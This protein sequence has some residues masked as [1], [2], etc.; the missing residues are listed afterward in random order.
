MASIKDV[1]EAAGVSTATVSR[2]LAN[3]PH[4]R[5]AVRERVLAAVEQLS[6]RPN[7][8]ARSLRAQQTRS[9]GLIVS[10]IR[11]PFFSEVS[12]AV[13]DTAYAH[14]YSVVL[15]NTDE[16]SDREEL[17]LNLMQDENVA[18]IILAPTRQ[19]IANF[20]ALSARLPIVMLDRT[21][22]NGDID[23]VLLDNIS[24]AYELTT[25]LI[26]QGYRRIG[27]VL[28]AVS[29]TGDERR[30]GYVQALGDH[31]IAP[32]ADLLRAVQPKIETGRAATLD[33]LDAARPPDAILAGNNLLAAG[34]LQAL[35]ERQRA[36]PDD[37]ALV[38]FDDTLWASLVQPT[39]TVMAQPTDEIGRTATELLLRRIADSSRS[40][41]KV[42]LQ[43]QLR[44]RGSSVRR[45]QGATDER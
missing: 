39:I 14:G 17:Y 41:R 16:R 34:A 37:V 28:G 22:K 4:I 12:R 18:G 31:G 29:L 30:Q 38:G 5:P 13:E 1:A 2:V 43:G 21:L 8:V 25:H 3:K 10:D 9:I 23:A 36:I 27:A 32:D 20:A 33:L 45:G 7:L 42:I 26:T 40:T 24:A 15:C 19:A 11:N 6:Y 35:R 44:V